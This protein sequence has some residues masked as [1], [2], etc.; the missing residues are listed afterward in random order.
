M[1][2]PTTITRDADT[3]DDGSGTT[4]TIHDNAWKT[5][6]YNRIDAALAILSAT[7]NWTPADA[8]GAALSLTVSTAGKYAKIGPMVFATAGITY[9]STASGLATLISGLPYVS[10]VQGALTIYYTTY[11]SA[12]ITGLVVAS[13]SQIAFYNHT[14]VALTNA[15]LSLKGVFFMAMYRTAS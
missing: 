12:D 8:S 13:A 9:P 5:A 11:G 6:F 15:N 7:G 1:A 4:G 3:D 2:Y 14:G 10:D